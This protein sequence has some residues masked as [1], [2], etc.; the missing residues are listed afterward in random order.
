VAA[1]ADASS[2]GWQLWAEACRRGLQQVA[3]VVVIGDGAHWSWN[4]AD[5]HFAG[6]TQI[7]D[8]Y[9]ASE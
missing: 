9:H 8:W 6:A 2:F 4:L 3:D 7:V 1:L 5:E